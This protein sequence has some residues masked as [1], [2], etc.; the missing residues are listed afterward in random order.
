MIEL[1]IEGV[2]Y[3]DDQSGQ[4]VLV[5]HYLTPYQNL[6]SCRGG[7]HDDD[8]DVRI[9]PTIG[10]QPP[11]LLQVARLLICVALHRTGVERCAFGSNKDFARRER[12]RSRGDRCKNM[13]RFIPDRILTR[14]DRIF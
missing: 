1:K 7:N 8:D 4:D 9:K 2:I 11:A 13:G 6:W 3:G 10:T 12:L 5:Y 14:K